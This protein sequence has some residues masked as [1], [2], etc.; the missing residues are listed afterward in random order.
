M[1]SPKTGLS[2]KSISSYANSEGFSKISDLVKRTSDKVPAFVQKKKIKD[3]VIKN[4]D[5]FD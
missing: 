4:T 2:K 3:E 5:L 1:V